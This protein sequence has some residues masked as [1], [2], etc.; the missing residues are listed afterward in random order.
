VVVPVPT[1]VNTPPAE[2]VPTD[3]VLLA[4]VPDVVESLNV[5]VEPMHATDEPTMEAGEEI[6]ESVVLVVQLPPSE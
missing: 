6:T 3:G 2:I 5:I 4:Q 1:A